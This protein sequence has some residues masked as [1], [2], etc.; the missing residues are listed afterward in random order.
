MQPGVR[1]WSAGRISDLFMSLKGAL[2]GRVYLE[3]KWEGTV[4]VSVVGLGRRTGSM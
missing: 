3:G 1:W 4:C 2:E